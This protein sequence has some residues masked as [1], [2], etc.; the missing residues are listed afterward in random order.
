MNT[1][2]VPPDT[3]TPLR[4]FVVEMT[5]LVERQPDEPQTL[6][7]GRSLLAKLLAD[8]TWLPESFAAP[9]ASSYRQYLLYCDPLERFSVVSFVWPAGA[10]TPIHNHTVW[11][12]VG[13]LRGAETCQEFTP[14]ADGHVRAAGVEHTML[15]GQ[16]EAVS[17]TVGDWHVVSNNTGQTAISIHVYGAN[18][19]AVRRQVYDPAEQRLKTFV[20]GYT[21]PVVPNL[22]DRSA[23]MRALG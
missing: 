18:I 14:G 2:A 22:W 9:D 19:G 21:L 13:V 15:R 4:Q 5:R 10:R 6:R 20:S 23:Q 8:D 7:E 17:P 11:G 1:A 3:L 12:L 16:I